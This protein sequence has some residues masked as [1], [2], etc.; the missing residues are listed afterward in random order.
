MRILKPSEKRWVNGNN[1]PIK[2]G[3]PKKSQTLK[4]AFRLNIQVY[5][6]VL[7]CLYFQLSIFYYTLK[8]FLFL[9]S[10]LND[11]GAKNSKPRTL[12]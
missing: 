9:G 8:I 4:K 7:K 3:F 11:L 12:T 10:F 2:Q 5:Y 6:I 1:I